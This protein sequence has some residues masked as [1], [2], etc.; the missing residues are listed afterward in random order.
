MAMTAV[1]AQ[2]I[3]QLRWTAENVCVAFHM[4]PYKINVGPPPNFNNIE[5]LDQQYYSQCLQTHLE[6]VEVLLDEGLGVSSDGAPQT[7]GTEFDLDDLL[8]M[9]TATRVKA[10]ADAVGSGAVSP[11]EARQKYF[12][13]G[14]V[15][16]GDA[17]YLQQQN[18]SLEA[19]SRRD[20]TFGVVPTAPLT[21][22]PNPNAA[23]PAMPMAPPSSADQAAADAQAAAKAIDEWRTREVEI[24]YAA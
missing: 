14:P 24:Q 21:Q 17:P 13:L 15:K 20:Q 10:A 2:L 19:L 6:S 8:R 18:Y 5:A 22:T 11:N 9:D 3:D 12:G 16:G 1:D 7:L 23:T 4:P